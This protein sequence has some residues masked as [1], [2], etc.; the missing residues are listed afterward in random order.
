MNRVLLAGAIA[1]SLLATSAHAGRRADAEHV[2]AQAIL[3]LEYG[4]PAEALE[5][6]QQFDRDPDYD[7]PAQVIRARALMDLEK[8]VEARQTFE[9][10][11]SHPHKTDEK[12]RVSYALLLHR[13]GEYLPEHTMPQLDRA[14]A[15]HPDLG[16]AHY[17]KGYFSYIAANCGAA[18]PS[19]DKAI[20]ARVNEAES[21]YYRGRCRM[22]ERN[23]D[24]AREEFAQARELGPQ[25]ELLDRIE[26][27]EQHMAD[28]TGGAWWEFWK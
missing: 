25:G 14:L 2:L 10:L 20:E 15:A 19:F 26:M 8:N 17:W 24:A 6:I 28:K 4:Q 12:W 3:A 18:L 11:A 23:F 5:R 21:R 22:A 16:E 27:A 13:M 1:L 9:A 7:F